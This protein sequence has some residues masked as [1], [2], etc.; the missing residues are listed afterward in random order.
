MG[1]K[2]RSQGISF[3]F[4]MWD[5]IE[6]RCKELKCGRSQYFQMLV[7]AD[8]KFTPM[9]HPHR[10]DGKWHLFTEAGEPALGKAAEPRAPYGREPSRR[11]KKIPL[12]PA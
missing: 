10:S 8:L 4:E 5:R 1:Q 2:T 3:T 6:E 7:E 12:P 9:S 11:T